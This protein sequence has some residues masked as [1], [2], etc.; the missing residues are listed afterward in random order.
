MKKVRINPGR[1]LR[2]FGGEHFQSEIKRLHRRIMRLNALK[3][4]SADVYQV[5]VK[6]TKVR[7]H[8]RQAHTR[9]VIKLRKGGK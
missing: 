4:G 6:P 5:S 7:A 2:L 3:T 9:V 1:Q 8:T